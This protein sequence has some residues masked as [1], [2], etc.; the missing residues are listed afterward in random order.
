MPERNLDFDRIINRHGTDCLKYDYA[1]KRGKP[2]DILPLWVADMDFVTSSY[3]QDALRETADYGIWG[4]SQPVGGYMDVLRDWMKRRHNWD[5]EEKWIVMTPG[6]VF[7]IAMAIRAFTRPGDGVLIQEPV[8]YP[9]ASEIRENG[10]RVVINELV[11]DRDSLTYHMDFGDFE[12]QITDNDVKLFILCNPHNPVGRVWTEGEL[13]TV[14]EICR[15]H[16]V[17]VVSDEI[18][19]DFI[20]EGEHRVF[21]GIDESF[22]DFTITCTAPS[23]TFNLAGLQL[24]NIVISNEDIRKRFKNEISATGYDE[25]GLFGLRACEAAYAHGEEW[26][27]AL[28]KYLKANLDYM[29]DYIRCEIPQIRM[30]RPQGTYLVWLDMKDLGLTPAELE[31]LIVNKAGLWL[32]RGSMFGSSGEGFE[33][34][35]VAC[36][37]ATLTE[38]LDRL[39]RAVR[40]L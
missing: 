34:V 7:A 5:I 25:P 8:Y 35:N 29:E 20:F 38:A 17:L 27:E 15:K 32:D 33:R 26:L 24:S 30:I 16:G 23:K 37:R 39:G 9:F 40:G 14:G 21:T 1:V 36:P 28:L 10:R 22:A 18:H 3:I 13:R 31:D 2:A 12:K 6:V 19:S 4:Y 11:Y